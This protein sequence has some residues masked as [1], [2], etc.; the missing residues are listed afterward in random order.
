[1]H[2]YATN[3]DERYRI[4]LVIAAVAFLIA[5]GTSAVLRRSG[6]DLPFW[7]EV[8]STAGLYGAG[9]ELFKHRVWRWRFL[10]WL[11]WVRTPKIDGKWTGVVRTSFDDHAKEHAVTVDI[12]QNWTEISVRLSSAHS[13]SHSS[14]GAITIDDAH[15][16]LSYEYIN[17]PLPGAIDTMHTHRGTAR[18]AISA[19]RGRLEG[20]YYSGRDRQN[21]GVLILER[22]A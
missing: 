7:V 17:E 20:E 22:K 9:Y 8:P 14:I 1:M 5:W 2:L 16:L 6:I 18:L 19:D 21:Q 13:G 15:N 10:S 11:R 3:S 4:P 12:K